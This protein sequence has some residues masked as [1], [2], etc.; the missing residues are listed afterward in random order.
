VVRG[1]RE[2]NAATMRGIVDSLEHLHS[3]IDSGVRN[4]AMLD[5]E[6]LLM[7]NRPGSI[8][9]KGGEIFP[10]PRQPMPYD[11]IRGGEPPAAR[12]QMMNSVV[13]SELLRRDMIENQIDQYKVE[14]YKKYSIPVACIVF[15]LIGVPLGIMSKRGGFGVA[16]SLS[17]GFF[18]LYWAFLSGGETLA[19]RNILAPF[20]AMWAANILLG[21][22]GCYLTVRIGKESVVFNWNA[23]R[24]VLP[25]RWRPADEPESSTVE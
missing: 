20:S 25:K 6:R 7:G 17:L 16:A 5:I 15:V 9:S 13:L 10:G 3:S 1:D 18:V 11:P 12:S 4:L 14:I 8:P 19:D 21:V 2:L 24:N 23:L 22:L